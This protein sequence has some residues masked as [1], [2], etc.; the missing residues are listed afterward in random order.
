MNLILLRHGEATDNV[1]ELI[2]DKEIYW[3]VLTEK[4]KE[5]VMESINYLP[6]NI[7]KVYVSP[8]PRTIQ[9]ANYVYEKYPNV[10]FIIDDR[11]REIKYGKYTHKKNNEE[12]DEV[13]NKQIKG[14]YFTRFGDYGENKYDI[15]L[16][17]SEF[18]IDIYINHKDD[19][20]ILIVTHGSIS[21]YIKRILKVKSLH[22][23]TGK[24][25]ILNDIDFEPT[26]K[27]MELLN[28]MK[29]KHDKDIVIKRN[30]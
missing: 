13:R 1:K 18:L 28:S 2:S 11:I 3:S 12:L 27:N 7:N 29:N 4:G 6:I 19:E 30:I 25:E 26:F 16:R 5:T 24:L 10:E 22:L 20:T 15:E 21:S 23:Q 14:D 9:T 8:L 17:L